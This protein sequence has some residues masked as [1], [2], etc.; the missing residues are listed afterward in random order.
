MQEKEIRCLIKEYS[1]A[2]LPPQ[3]LPLVEKA[4]EMTSTSYAPYSHFHVGAAIELESGAI[5]GGSNQENAAFP[6]TMCAE[7]SAAFWAGANYP[8]VA[9]RRIA[10]AA[11]TP[12]GFQRNPVSPCGTC[13]QALLEFEKRFGAIEVVLYGADRT[14]VLP[15]VSSLMPLSFTEF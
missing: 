7:R 14:Y 12:D 8:G 11:R 13:R 6:A 15:S 9:F 5:V 4:K 1:S 3:L 2:E 10:V